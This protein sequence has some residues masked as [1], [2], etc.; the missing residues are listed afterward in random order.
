MNR[1]IADLLQVELGGLDLAALQVRVAVGRVALEGAVEPR[2]GL[3]EAL[4]CGDPE[5]LRQV[6]DAVPRLDTQVGSG[7]ES[8]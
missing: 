7:P 1:E 4:G 2:Q 6:T 8:T 5:L 3:V